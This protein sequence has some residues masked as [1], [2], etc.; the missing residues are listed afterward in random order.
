MKYRW[1]IIFLG[2]TLTLILNFK[3]SHAAEI[4]TE[5]LRTQAV[6][7][8]DI[9]QGGDSKGDCIIK[10]YVSSLMENSK[11]VLDS[12]VSEYDKK[13]FSE[14]SKDRK[15]AY[16]ERYKN[17]P[18][19]IKKDAEGMGN[20]FKSL[21]AKG[22]DGVS[23]E[24]LESLDEHQRTDLLLSCINSERLALKYDY[25]AYCDHVGDYDAPGQVTC[26]DEVSSYFEEHYGAI[27]NLSDIDMLSMMQQ[28]LGKTMVSPKSLTFHFGWKILIALLAVGLINF[29]FTKN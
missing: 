22:T 2:L 15:K 14:W 4:D 19:S 7:I 21:A 25:Y 1:V 10:T 17:D 27:K 8:C 6:K 3:A 11:S 12:K 23:P 28:D 18:D 24:Y 26:K 5:L 29:I 9:S 20:A 13:C 16:A